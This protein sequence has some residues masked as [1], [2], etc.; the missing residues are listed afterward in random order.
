ME[1]RLLFIK[2]IFVFDKFKRQ[3]LYEQNVIKLNLIKNRNLIKV[4]RAKQV[5]KRI[6][7]F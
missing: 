2:I 4:G 3:S 6:I 1:A 5:N 7:I